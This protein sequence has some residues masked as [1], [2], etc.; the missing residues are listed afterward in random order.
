MTGALL[1]RSLIKPTP[2]VPNYGFRF[3]FGMH[4]SI[5]KRSFGVN[6]LDMIRKDLPQGPP[7]RMTHHGPPQ[8][9]FG[10]PHIWCVLMIEPRVNLI[11]SQIAPFFSSCEKQGRIVLWTVTS[12][13]SIHSYV[14]GFNSIDGEEV[15]G[16]HLVL[17]LH[18]LQQNLYCISKWTM[19]QK[20]GLS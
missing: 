11:P 1:R 12:V 16:C 15:I 7:Q 9:G 17:L 14:G 10:F 3:R 13:D 5:G 6:K 4:L 19:K 2:L 18:V 8:K 20:L